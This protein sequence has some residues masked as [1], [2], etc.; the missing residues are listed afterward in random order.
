MY[1]PLTV[2]LINIRA[3]IALIL[4]ISMPSFLCAQRRGCLLLEE[5]SIP[6]NQK[7]YFYEIRSIRKYKDRVYYFSPRGIEAYELK[8]EL[9]HI[10]PVYRKYRSY[11]YPHKIIQRKLTHPAV[12]PMYQVLDSFFVIAPTCA[13][14]FIL[15][16]KF[17]GKHLK[18][19]EYRSSNSN[20]DYFYS[21]AHPNYK[22]YNNTSSEPRFFVHR[23]RLFL[24]IYAIDSM[25]SYIYNHSCTL[26]SFDNSIINASLPVMLQSKIEKGPFKLLQDTCPIT[27]AK[28]YFFSAL[29]FFGKRD[30]K[31]AYA[32]S[33]NK[34][35]PCGGTD[36]NFAIDTLHNKTFITPDSYSSQLQICELG[37]KQND[38][39]L[40]WN[41]FDSEKDNIPEN[42]LSLISLPKQLNS[43]WTMQEV[44]RWERI[45]DRKK[46]EAFLASKFFKQTYYSHPHNLVF[47]IRQFPDS[48]Y[49]EKVIQKLAS[50]NDLKRIA[51]LF[52]R[53]TFLQILDPEKPGGLIAEIPVPPHFRILDAEPGGVIWAVKEVNKKEIIVAKYRLDLEGLKEAKS[54]GKE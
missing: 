18:I 7:Y 17:T 37:K 27:G 21:P 40:C 43:D 15:I 23:D 22:F 5:F 41:Y 51:A 12:R 1:I 11:Y 47:R 45:I 46:K 39:I 3:T 16:D 44:K 38:A 36:Y 52:N 19:I 6:Q 30:E 26:S 10:T 31:I 35:C 28:Y 25:P 8:G 50:K 2:Y 42:P 32:A 14:E 49:T 24:P 29:N 54:E 20:M 4:I 9:K 34:F 48:S 13:S 53:P 33:Q